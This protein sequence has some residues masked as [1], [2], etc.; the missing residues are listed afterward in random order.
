MGVR[1]LVSVLAMLVA[2]AALAADAPP[3]V[4]YLYG[5]TDLDKLKAANP[6]H[7]ARAERIIAASAELCKPG[8]DQVY[9]ARFEATNIS[10]QSLF[11]KTSN[12]PKREIGFTLDDVRYVALITIRDAGPRFRRVP[13]E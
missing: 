12:P 4:V 10:C 5:S 8:P 7:Y 9:Y 13:A 1:T 6:D 3:K 11:L 2:G